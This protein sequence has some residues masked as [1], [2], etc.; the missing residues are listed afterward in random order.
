MSPLKQNYKFRQ[1][2]G[3]ETRILCHKGG[4]VL[5]PNENSWNQFYEKLFF[6]LTACDVH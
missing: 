2:A 1:A 4:T 3:Q 6:M 5:V